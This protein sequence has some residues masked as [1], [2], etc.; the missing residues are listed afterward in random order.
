MYLNRNMNVFKAILL[1]FV[2]IILPYLFLQYIRHDNKFTTHILQ[3][4]M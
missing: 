1:Y 2:Q 3:L 4:L